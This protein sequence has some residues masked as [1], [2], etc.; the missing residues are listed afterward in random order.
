MSLAAYLDALYGAEPDGSFAEV[1]FKLRN[2]GMGREFV[3]VG[4]RRRLAAMVEARGRTT[5]TYIGVAPRTRHE[6]GRDAVER[7]HALWADCD[8]P[9]AIAALE[10]FDPPP[11]MV[12]HSGSGRHA[13]FALWPPVGPDETETANRR[14]AHALGA[15]MRATDAARILR[16]PSTFNFKGTF[17]GTGPKPVAVEHV[18]VEVYTLDQVVG[19]LPDPDPERLPR[20]PVRLRVATDDALLAVAPAVYVEALTGREVGRDGKIPCP[21]H[22][23]RTPSL[24]VFAEPERGWTCFG[25]RRGGTAIDFGAHLWGLEPRGR[26]YWEL[27]RGLEAALGMEVA[28]RPG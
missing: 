24:H 26:G 15:D 6:G 1:R 25:C 21:F 3:A 11:S 19:A 22:D 10:S 5:D 13:Y 8:T 16:P 20:R 28:A 4:D 17:K 14:I 7:V 18:N 23:D 2:G 12:V 27:R 9:E